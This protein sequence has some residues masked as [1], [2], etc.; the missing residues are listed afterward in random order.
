MGSEDNNEPNKVVR[1]D[2]NGYIKA[3]GFIVSQPE[4]ASTT[5]VYV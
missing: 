3:K 4:N 1:T 5:P 2:A